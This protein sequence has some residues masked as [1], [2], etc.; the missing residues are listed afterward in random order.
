MSKIATK[1]HLRVAN[2]AFVDGSVLAVPL[3]ELWSLDWQ[4]HW[5][6]PSP[7]PRVPW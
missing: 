5:V 4:D 6:P 7:L 2:V 1:R 3:P